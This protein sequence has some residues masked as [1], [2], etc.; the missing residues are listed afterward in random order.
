MIFIIRAVEDV[1]MGTESILVVLPRMTTPDY[2]L[3]NSDLFDLFWLT[4]LNF[5]ELVPIIDSQVSLAR[6]TGVFKK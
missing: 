1:T 3:I 2:Y 5:P 6:V 4:M